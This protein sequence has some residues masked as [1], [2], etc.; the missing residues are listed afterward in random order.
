L[1][2]TAFIGIS[3]CANQSYLKT[4]AGFRPEGWERIVVLPFTGKGQYVDLATSTFTLQMVGQQH[5]MLVQPDETRVKLTQLGVAI[6]TDTLSVVEAQKVARVF[7]AQGILMGNIDSYNNGMTLNAFATV[8]LV[9]ATSGRIVAATH[10][11]S[12]LLFAY[13]EQ[14]C[15]VAAI[16]KAASKINKVLGDL[17]EHNIGLPARPAILTM[18]RGNQT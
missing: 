4:D 16:E 13:S 15:V 1:V 9:D 11:P 8:R 2:I 17:A 14:Q 6:G 5:F 10:Q 18:R 12:G 7:N 3:G